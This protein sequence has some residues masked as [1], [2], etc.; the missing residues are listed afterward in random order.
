MINCYYFPLCPSSHPF[1]LHQ[2]AACCLTQESQ[3]LAYRPH[4]HRHRLVQEPIRQLRALDKNYYYYYNSSLIDTFPMRTRPVLSC[5][6][7]SYLSLGYCCALWCAF[8]PNP[9]T[10]NLPSLCSAA[11]RPCV[12]FFFCLSADCLIRSLFL[13]CP[14]Q[15][16]ASFHTPSR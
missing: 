3:S 12:A 4:R 10:I 16:E 14:W 9:Y 2:A 7:L 11:N 13:L 6:V 8:H 1:V 15:I 5:S